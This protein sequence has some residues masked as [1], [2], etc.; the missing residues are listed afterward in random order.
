MENK[1]ISQIALEKIKESGRKPIS[2]YVFNFKRV[3]F[4]SLVGISLVFGAISFSILISILFNNDWY[5]YNR[6]GFNFILKSLPYFWFLFLVIFTILGDYYYRKTFLGYRRSTI[7]I[8]FIYITLTVISGSILSVIGVGQSLEKSLSENVSVY[9]GFMF[10]KNEFWSHP[11]RGLL[12]GTIISIEDD[13]IK[14]VDQNGVIWIINTEGASFG[15]RAQ[16]KVGEIIKIIG[17][18]DMDDNFKANEIRPWMGNK[19]KQNININYMMR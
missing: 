8:I 16:I 19:H 18:K 1:D 7:T 11:E 9:R 17:D 14:V 10:D 13:F 3:L 5:L 2:K 4:W 6:F 15:T 12:F